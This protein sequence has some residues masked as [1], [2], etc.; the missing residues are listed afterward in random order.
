[1][2]VSHAHS[3]LLGAGHCCLSNQAVRIEKEGKPLCLA[4][5]DD[6]LALL[7]GSR[8]GRA[9]MGGLD[10]LDSTLKD[11]TDEAPIPLLAHEPHIFN[12]VPERV[13]LTLS[14]HTHGRSDHLF[15]WRLWAA[16][17][18]RDGASHFFR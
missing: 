7:P 18:D 5:L 16:S 12:N 1:V 8:Y 14:G 2:T 6:Q 4:G 10:D 13:S 17:G 3:A 15:G 11:V 9:R